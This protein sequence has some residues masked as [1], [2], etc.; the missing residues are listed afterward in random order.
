MRGRAGV[1]ESLR[2]RN[3]DLRLE[4]RGGGGLVPKQR[5]GSEDI[6]THA[7]ALA[8]SSSRCPPPRKVCTWPRVTDTRGQHAS[9]TTRLLLSQTK[10]L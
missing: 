5:F 7:H 9:L 6:P 1:N 10:K 4:G 2:R 3:N 8:I